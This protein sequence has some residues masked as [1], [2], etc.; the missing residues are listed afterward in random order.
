MTRTNMTLIMVLAFCGV[1][2]AKVEVGSSHA[3]PAMGDDYLW[4]KKRLFNPTEAQRRE[5]ARG[6]IFIYHNLKRSDVSQAMDEHFDRIDSMMFTSTVITDD[7][8]TVVRDGNTGE[9]VV[10]DDGCDE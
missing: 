5:E 9:A 8:G 3:S 4:Q 1:S 7:R 10:E 6:R 2:L